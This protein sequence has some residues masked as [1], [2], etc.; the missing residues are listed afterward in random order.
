MLF[1][2]F[3]RGQNGKSTKRITRSSSKN[4]QKNTA[5]A[6]QNT[7][8]SDSPTSQKLT[9]D[10]EDTEDADDEWDE[11]DEE[12]EEAGTTGTAGKTRVRGRQGQALLYIENPKSDEEDD[13]F[14]RKSE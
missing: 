4:D 12:D 7:V 9:Q 5:K 2:E 8:C 13:P 3:A 11:E 10:G 14:N 6:N 1:H